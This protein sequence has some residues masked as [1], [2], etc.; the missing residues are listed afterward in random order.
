MPRALN[1]DERRDMAFT[2]GLNRIAAT[3]QGSRLGLTAGGNFHVGGEFT[4]TA[5]I[6]NPEA[7]QRVKLEDLADGLQLVKG[8]EI[9]QNVP[10]GNEYSQVSWRIRGARAGTYTL[11]A[12][13]GTAR[14]EYPVTIRA[15]GIFEK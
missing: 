2:Y 13:A 15:G 10:A 11:A 4:L 3:G 14:V 1:P 8:Q 5:Y 12:T 7:G 6:K 9:E